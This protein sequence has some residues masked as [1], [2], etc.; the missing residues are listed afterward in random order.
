MF[1][2]S[3]LGNPVTQAMS[4]PVVPVRRRRIVRL[5]RL[6]VFT[7][8][9]IPL[10]VWLLTPIVV[11]YNILHPRHVAVTTT[12]S[13][14]PF[15]AENVSIQASDGVTLRGWF[16]R[17]SATAPVIL[18]GHGFE[19]TRANMIPYGDFLYQDGYSVLLLDWRAWGDSGGDMTTFGR[20]ESGDISAALDYL[21]AR[22]DL[23]HP[24][25]AALGVS[26]GS[27]LML[28]AA[29]H[30][31][32]LVAVVCD[33]LYIYPTFVNL[34]HDWD[35]N[36]MPVGNGRVP[37]APLTA[38]MA[39]WMLGGHMEELDPLKE[40][41]NVA[42]TALLVIHALHD[43]HPMT[44]VSGAEQVFAAA[45]EPKAEWISPV[46]DHASVFFADPDG[47]RQHV[48]TFLDTY[49]RGK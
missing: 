7:L 42:P 30:D 35:T 10:T 20:R 32:R 8:V 23:D 9:A 43:H 11:V 39:N 37:S 6:A 36:G 41:P 45:Q 14:L 22:P 44:P 17:R 5:L 2:R 49:V 28:Q 21:T 13:Q 1:G 47:Y 27:A 40:A 12:L 18:V 26:Y 16:A 15:P 48:L 34:F 31:H 3:N 33:S 25:F 4:R 24:H 29:A 46:G 19:N 38:F